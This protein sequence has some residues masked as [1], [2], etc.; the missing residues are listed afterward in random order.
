MFFWNGNEWISLIMRGKYAANW[1]TIQHGNYLPKPINE[2][3]KIFDYS[4]CIWN[5]SPASINGQIDMFS[6]NTNSNGLVTMQYRNVDSNILVN[7]IANYLI[8]GIEGNVNNGTYMPPYQVSPTPTAT[9]VGT[10]ASTPV[11]TVSGTPQ[12]T[13]GATPTRTPDVTPTRMP[14]PGVSPSGTPAIT[15]TSTPQPTP[16]VTPSSHIPLSSIV[17]TDSFWANSQVVA[18]ACTGAGIGFQSNGGVGKTG[19]RSGGIDRWLVT[20]YNASDFEISFDGEWLDDP[21][22]INPSGFYHTP[23]GDNTMGASGEWYNMG[24]GVS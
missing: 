24:A 9:P 21:P 13:V 18:G 11:P 1:G 4:E 17:F 2:E 22:R 5:V 3:G 7:S 23:A 19:L 6:C 20:G 15:P 16:A 8:I 12:A 14:T 10:P